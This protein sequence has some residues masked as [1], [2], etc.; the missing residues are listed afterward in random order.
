MP[1]RRPSSTHIKRTTP[2]ERLPRPPRWAGRTQLGI[3]ADAHCG[4]SPAVC[5]PPT[6]RPW[7][8]PSRHASPAPAGRRSR[9][10]HVPAL[11]VVGGGGSR[12]RRAVESRSAEPRAIWAGWVTRRWSRTFN[13]RPR[14]NYRRCGRQIYSLRVIDA[15]CNL[16]SAGHRSMKQST[17]QFY[18]PSINHQSLTINAA[19]ASDDTAGFRRRAAV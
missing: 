16:G 6:H 10:P 9:C 12:A 7:I 13:W 4:S 3:P 15:D 1:D 2:S 8:G 5:G 17:A 19:I 11:R 14:W 18:S